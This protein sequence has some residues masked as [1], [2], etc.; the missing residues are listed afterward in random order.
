MR[1]L[2]LKK[3]EKKVEE[4][5]VE[6][7]KVE[8]KKDKIEIKEEKPIPTQNSNKNDIKVKEKND[9]KEESKVEP[10]EE[11]DMSAVL[12]KREALIKKHADIE[13]FN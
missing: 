10:T 8:E 2:G 5:K 1:K 3:K 9:K 11:L 7:K 6:E 13:E 4:K 12:K